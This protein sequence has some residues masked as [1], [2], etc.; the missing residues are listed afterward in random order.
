MARQGWRIL[1]RNY[2]YIGCELDVVASKGR[3]TIIVEV[4]RRRYP[5]RTLAEGD[6]LL[7]WRKRLALKRGADAFLAR[8]RHRAET[9]RFDLAIVHGT[10]A[11]PEIKYVVDIR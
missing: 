7:P 10:T 11:R 9:I 3:T 5:P 4:K 1:A 6:M 2:R 8:T